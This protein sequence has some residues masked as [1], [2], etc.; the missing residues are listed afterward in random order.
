MLT[1]FII[2]IN[3]HVVK[4]FVAVSQTLHNRTYMYMLHIQI[5]PGSKGCQKLPAPSTVN[6]PATL[7]FLLAKNGH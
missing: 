2:V 5:R 6:I 1:K 7:W 3:L 4:I